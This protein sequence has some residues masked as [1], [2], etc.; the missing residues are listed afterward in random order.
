MLIPSC[1]YTI[2]R[3]RPLTQPSNDGVAGSATQKKLTH[4]ATPVFVKSQHGTKKN[5][6]YNPIIP[7]R[8]LRRR[9][10]ISTRVYYSYFSR[11]RTADCVIMCCVAYLSWSGH[12]KGGKTFDNMNYSFK[13]KGTES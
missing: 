11:S 6:H 9:R 10:N 4:V 7:A 1:P 3:C 13:T 12:E 5:I 8:A 2:G